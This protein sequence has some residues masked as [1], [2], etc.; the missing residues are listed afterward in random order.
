MACG[1][2]LRKNPPLPSFEAPSLCREGGRLYL[3]DTPSTDSGQALRLPAKGL[4]LCTTRI[5]AACQR[6]IPACLGDVYSTG[7]VPIGQMSLIPTRPP[8]E[9]GGCAPRPPARGANP[10]GLP[11]GTSWSLNSLANLCHV[12]NRFKPPTGRLSVHEAGCCQSAPPRHVGRGTGPSG[13]AGSSRSQETCRGI[14]KAAMP[15]WV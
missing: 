8:L 5:S 13:V 9:T 12:G 10:S 14:W 2:R 15:C 7:I 6:V 11:L 1:S 4:A 3:R